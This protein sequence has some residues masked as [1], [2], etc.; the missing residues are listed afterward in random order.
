MGDLRNG[1]K[2]LQVEHLENEELKSRCLSSICKTLNIPISI[3]GARP[4]EHLRVSELKELETP[5]MISSLY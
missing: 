3:G 1:L 5:L 4:W 2:R